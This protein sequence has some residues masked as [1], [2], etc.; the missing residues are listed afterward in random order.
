MKCIDSPDRRY[1]VDFNTFEM[2]MSHW[3]SVP[4]V[5]DTVTGQPVMDLSHTLWHADDVHWD[6]AGV[7]VTLSLRHYPDDRPGIALTI[8]LA[9]R[10]CT[11]R[12]TSETLRMSLVYAVQWLEAYANG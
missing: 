8:D 12:T 7:Q 4:C 1:V 9:E 5:R 3:I 2:R 11:I 6:D 10:Y